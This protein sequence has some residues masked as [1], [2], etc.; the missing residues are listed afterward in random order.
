VILQDTEQYEVRSHDDKGERPSK[1]CEQR[2]QK[3]TTKS[4]TKCKQE[5]NECQSAAD[6][7]E[8][9][10]TGESLG[11]VL[12]GRVEFGLVNVGHHLGWVVT[13]LLAG[14]EIL[15]VVLAEGLVRI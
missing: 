13:N 5:C 9:H 1:G 4:R 15:T 7:V 14:A 12:L 8:N 10:D 3:A 6:W 2:S 11:G